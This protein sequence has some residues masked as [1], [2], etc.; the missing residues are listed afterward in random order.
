LQIVAAAVSCAHGRNEL[1]GPDADRIHAAP[2]EID[3]ISDD[4]VSAVEGD[5]TDWRFID[6]PQPGTI[7]LQLHWDD[8]RAALALEL[9]DALG[10]QLST[11]EA[12]GQTGRQVRY[13]VPAKD[14]YY[15]KVEA[16]KDSDASTY[17][18]K[19]TFQKRAPKTCHD[20]T[21]G[22]QICVGKDGFAAC[23]QTREGCNAWVEIL[24]CEGD[25]T[26]KEGQCVAGCTDQCKPDERRCASE[27]ASQI[28]VRGPTG[29]LQW[30]VPAPCGTGSACELGKCKKSK[31][32]VK[33]PPPDAPKDVYVS[34]RII[35]MYTQEGKRVLHIEIGE[36]KGVTPG[37]SGMVLEGDTDEPVSNG[38]FK[39]IRVTGK[40]CIAETGLE[41]IGN[42]RSVRIKVR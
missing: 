25:Q 11:G 19:A 3:T 20:C 5:A 36:D 24:A 26:C 38:Q 12:F 40:F 30:D 14:R 17:S 33:P 32:Q 37:M 41:A 16:Q 6:A 4:T 42:N 35:T 18:L 2:L 34:G 22:Q 39:V 28:C 29:C 27:G 31:K 7:D 1:S 15:V 9:Y 10:K 23:A 21:V 13:D 8:G